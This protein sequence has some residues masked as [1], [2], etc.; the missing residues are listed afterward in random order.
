MPCSWSK[1]YQSLSE[2]ARLCDLVSPE[3]ASR[4][5]HKPPTPMQQP[6]TLSVPP[7]ILF[8]RVLHL[9]LFLPGIVPATHDSDILTL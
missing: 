2:P 7:D 1:V 8:H 4:I 9:Q 3:L 6:L 5:S